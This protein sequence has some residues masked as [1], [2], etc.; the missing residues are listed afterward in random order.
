M[1]PVDADQQQGLAVGRKVCPRDGTA[2]VACEEAWLL[3]HQRYPHF[4]CR[5]FTHSAAMDPGEGPTIARTGDRLDG[6]F[7]LPGGPRITPL[8]ADPPRPREHKV[9]FLRGRAGDD[10]PA[11]VAPR[12]A[13]PLVVWRRDCPCCAPRRVHDPESGE[14]WIVIYVDS[15]VALLLMLL[16][17]LRLPARPAVPT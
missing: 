2:V 1:R 11:V 3:V 4:I 14:L 7:A 16:L 6:V 10:G 5:F 8:A 12:E 17:I 15:V 13:A 9:V